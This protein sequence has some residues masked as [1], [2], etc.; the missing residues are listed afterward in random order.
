MTDGPDLVSDELCSFTE[1]ANTFSPVTLSFSQYNS[2][3]STCVYV[4]GDREWKE[5]DKDTFS[6]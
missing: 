1:M 3:N 2:S 5:R 4:L 6:L